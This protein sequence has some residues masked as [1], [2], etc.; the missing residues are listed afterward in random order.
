MTLEELQKR[1]I[2]LLK[3]IEKTNKSIGDI[4][5]KTKTKEFVSEYFELCYDFNVKGITEEQERIFRQSVAEYI[6]KTIKKAL[7]FQYVF[8]NN[9]KDISV[10]TKNVKV[11]VE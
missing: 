2:E 8:Y 5:R 7:P 11:F 4:E 1:R 6:T 9:G 3:E 10:K